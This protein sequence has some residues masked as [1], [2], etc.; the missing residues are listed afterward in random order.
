MAIGRTDERDTPCHPPAALPCRSRVE[1]SLADTIWAAVIDTAPQGRTHDR[2]RTHRRSFSARTPCTQRAVHTWV[3]GLRP[4]RRRTAERRLMLAR[5]GGCP[6]STSGWGRLRIATR[7]VAPSL[8]QP[9][10]GSGPPPATTWYA[11]PRSFPTQDRQSASQP[12]IVSRRPGRP[13]PSA[14]PGR[15]IP[16]RAACCAA[17]PGPASAKPRR[18][19]TDAGPGRFLPPRGRRPPPAATA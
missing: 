7:A 17:M 18:R 11:S 4:P 13:P 15:G 3:A 14:A 5:M 6:P 1:G 2:T 10:V 16:P 9:I 19:P 8:L 12:P